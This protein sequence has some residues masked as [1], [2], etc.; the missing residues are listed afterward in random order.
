M[1]NQPASV[2]VPGR[3]GYSAPRRRQWRSIRRLLLLVVLP[4]VLVAGAVYLYLGPVHDAENSARD[5]ARQIEAARLQLVGNAGDITA[6]RLATVRVRLTKA[7]ADV[8][9]LQS[10]EGQYGTLLG[11]AARI[12]TVGDRVH[13]ARGLVAMADKSLH[14]AD[15]A[16]VAGQGLVEAE[17]STGHKRASATLLTS[18]VDQQGSL[19]RARTFLAQAQVLAASL[20][21]STGLGSS[22]DHLLATFRANSTSADEALGTLLDVASLAQRRTTLLLASQDPDEQR[23]TGGLIGFSGLLHIDRDGLRIDSI[24]PSGNVDLQFAPESPN[25][26]EMPGTVAAPLAGAYYASWQA[27]YF[28]DANWSPDFPTSARQML[29]FYTRGQDV[30]ADGVIAIEPSLIRPL[31]ALTGPVVVP[32]R[33]A[34]LTVDNAMEQLRYH[35]YVLNEKQFTVQSWQAVADRLLR[36]PASDAFKLARIGME[37]MQDRTASIYLEDPRIEA[38]LRANGLDGAVTQGNGDYLYVVDTNLGY[39]KVDPYIRRNVSLTVTPRPD[40]S[41]VHVLTI[42]YLNSLP[43]NR[44]LGIDQGGKNITYV[45]YLRVIVP[46]SSILVSQKGWEGWAP[47]TINGLRQYSGGLSVAPGHTETVTLTYRSPPIHTGA[48]YSLHVQAQPGGYAAT[49]SACLVTKTESQCYPGASTTF[50]WKP[51]HAS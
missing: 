29:T 36:L 41:T 47:A 32:G 9:H 39:N 35:E 4:T 31:L 14:A 49:V 19:E 51:R 34:T 26:P 25:S 17:H 45:D 33:G 8:T 24:M 18:L 12:P 3:A 27:W 13:T 10:L 2:R 48:P 46:A 28:R 22:A 7:R 5:A 38:R 42:N 6:A 50:D 15:A 44:V 43:P 1:I 16:L 11:L 23:P 40:G 37:A 30:R 20:P 21:G